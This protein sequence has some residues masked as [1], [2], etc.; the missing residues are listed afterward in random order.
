MKSG[1]AL[2]VLALAAGCGRAGE[3][4]SDAAEAGLMPVVGPQV[5]HA[6]APRPALPPNIYYDL[7]RF[8]WYARGEP[9]V[10][11]DVAFTAT[12]VPV[13]LPLAELE[14]AGNYQ[15]VDFYQHRSAADRDAV[16]YVPVYEGF[17]LRFSAEPTR[18]AAP[19]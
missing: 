18:T 19:D 3:A 11:D 10:Q 7:T 17:W 16:R 9:L 4:G 13:A 8:E 15:G 14:H 1:T 5:A 12:G 6:E 2:F